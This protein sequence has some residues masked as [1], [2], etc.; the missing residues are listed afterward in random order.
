MEMRGR[1]S[2][3]GEGTSS[4]KEITGQPPYSI[5]EDIKSSNMGTD[6]ENEIILSY[7]K[8]IDRCLQDSK[9]LIENISGKNEIRDFIKNICICNGNSRS[10]KDGIKQNFTNFTETVEHI[11]SYME[12][13]YIP[14]EE[15][16]KCLQ[17]AHD[18]SQKLPGFL[19]DAI[20]GSSNQKRTNAK[21]NIDL[22]NESIK[23][24]EI[25]TKYLDT[26]SQFSKECIQLKETLDKVPTDEVINRA[27]KI[28]T[29]IERRV[30][31]AYKKI[32]SQKEINELERY[33]KIFSEA[34]SQLHTLSTLVTNNLSRQA[35]GSAETLPNLNEEL[36]R[37]SV[38]RFD[39]KA[40]LDDQ[41]PLERTVSSQKSG[42]DPLMKEY[43]EENELQN[44]IEKRLLAEE[45][46][47]KGNYIRDLLDNLVETELMGI[48][49][50]LPDLEINRKIAEA[51]EQFI[52]LLKDQD[53]VHISSELKYKLIDIVHHVV[54][55]DNNEDKKEKL[56]I[57]KK[58]LRS[59]VEDIQSEWSSVRKLIINKHFFQQDD[60]LYK[61]LEQKTYDRIETILDEKEMLVNEAY[62]KLLECYQSPNDWLEPKRHF[63]A[64]C[65]QFNTFKKNLDN[66]TEAWKQ[67]QDYLQLLSGRLTPHYFHD[68]PHSEKSKLEHTAVRNIKENLA[69]VPEKTRKR[70]MELAKSQVNRATEVYEQILTC[71][72]EG[73]NP[74][75]NHKK[76]LLDVCSRLI[77]LI[78]VPS[79]LKCIQDYQVTFK[80][81]GIDTSKFDIDKQ[82][83]KA[84]AASTQVLNFCQDN[85]RKDEFQESYDQLD[86]A[87]KELKKLM[88]TNTD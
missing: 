48:S 74:P 81:A 68:F 6:D 70:I 52:K 72:E 39:E 12:A 37:F 2:A 27:K 57:K 35:E 58:K 60:K 41:C 55:E 49:S 29:K 61:D 28:T 79:K 25:N 4:R 7:K 82:V 17:Q 13:L 86:E 80:A 46:S 71:Y 85:S 3:S 1:H 62:T 14:L 43:K 36:K 51:A 65:N 53:C 16:V 24:L 56:I 30:E 26:W 9:K 34:C 64:V 87:L 66:F 21:D 33:C 15:K 54:K 73:N 20:N 69:S 76:D 47:D 50:N 84:E 63:K 11:Q 8:D 44:I 40:P 75:L 23:R 38:V 83:E 45:K 77:I 42:A 19:K 78:N 88:D 32:L 22:L 59:M 18:L 67:S 31:M 10:N 5:K